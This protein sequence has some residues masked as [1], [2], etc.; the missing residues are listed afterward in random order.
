MNWCPI[1]WSNLRNAPH[2]PAV[3]LQEPAEAT[4]VVPKL[5]TPFPKDSLR[6]IAPLSTTSRDGSQVATPKTPASKGGSFVFV[7]EAG[8]HIGVKS[9]YL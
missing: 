2:K 1:E 7:G 6:I 9:E 3:L 8:A 4:P 5:P